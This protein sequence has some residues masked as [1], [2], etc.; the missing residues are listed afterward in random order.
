MTQADD[1]YSYKPLV[2]LERPVALVGLPGCHAMQTARVA[3][4]ITGLEVRMLPRSVAHMVGMDPEGLIL[5]GR[6]GELHDAELEI[7]KEALNKRSPPLLALGP[8]TLESPA[9]QQLLLEKTHIV[10]LA[11]TVPEAFD[12]LQDDMVEDPRKHQHLRKHGPIS[13]SNLKLLFHQRLR[14]FSAMAKTEVQVGGRP[15]LK[16]GRELPGVLGW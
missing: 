10:H 6:D 12:A 7:V 3:A 4:M 11:L 1:Y 5:Q 15:P 16:V 9:V 14:L 13:Q 8:T 2:R